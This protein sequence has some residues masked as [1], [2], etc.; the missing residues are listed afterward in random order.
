M[1]NL[2]N[3]KLK[4][5]KKKKKKRKLLYSFEKSK[6]AKFGVKFFTLL[7][8]FM[9]VMGPSG[10]ECEK[11]CDFFFSMALTKLL[12]IPKIVSKSRSAHVLEIISA[13]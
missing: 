7:L 3:N 6:D 8:L 11:W 9:F 4:K 13:K 5:K 12:P 1:A 2:K 10:M